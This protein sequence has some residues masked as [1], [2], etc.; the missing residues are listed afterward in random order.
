MTAVSLAHLT[1][2]DAAPLELI[3]AAATAGFR[4][5]GLRIVPP[6]PDPAW[7]S[8][9]GNRQAEREVKQ[10]LAATGVRILD[11]EAFWM[12]PG[13]RV[14]ACWAAF[15]LGAELGARY[16]VVICDDPER[17]RTIANF[18]NLCTLAAEFGLKP[19]LEFIPYTHVAR[20]ADA[21]EI[22]R[23]AQGAN[24]GLLID[25]LHLIRSGGS[26]AD[27][28]QVPPALM[29]FAHVCDAPAAI[30]KTIDELRREARGGRLYPGEGALA[31]R[32]F[33]A[34]LPADTPVALEAPNPRYAH[35][36]F[37]ERAQRAHGAMARA[38][39]EDRT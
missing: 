36:P 1:M 13:F 22:V 20:L 26:P 11:I 18:A 17:S 27:L 10:R 14:E 15:A 31:V 2:L 21:L 39:G 5:V 33:L 24:A 35:L 7:R 23:A 9:V 16:L 3:D 28:T 29:H 6:M 34:A 37:A 32:A 38:L 4:H 25:L 30:P 8:I 19:A 12:G